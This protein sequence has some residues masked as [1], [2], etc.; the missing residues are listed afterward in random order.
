MSTTTLTKLLAVG[1]VASSQLAQS[2]NAASHLASSTLAEVSVEFGTATVK[3]SGE[4]EGI[5]DNW[6]GGESSL[7]VPVAVTTSPD[8]GGIKGMIYLKKCLNLK[9]LASL[10]QFF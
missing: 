4:D 9:L 3:L 7:S 10:V 5:T 8:T 6:V 2:A 1:C